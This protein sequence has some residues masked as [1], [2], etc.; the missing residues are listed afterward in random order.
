MSRV[1]GGGGA[2]GVPVAASSSSAVVPC[3]VRNS[4]AGALTF[5]PCGN[6][7]GATGVPPIAIVEATRSASCSVLSVIRNAVAPAQ[8]LHPQLDEVGR[9]V[10]RTPRR[11]GTC[12]CRGAGERVVAGARVGRNARAAAARRCRRRGSPGRGTRHRDRRSPPRR[13]SA[14]PSSRRRSGAAARRPA[15]RRG[16]RDRA[17]AR[18]LGKRACVGERRRCR[19]PEHDRCPCDP[20]H[21]HPGRKLLGAR[22]RGAGWSRA[23][24]A[25]ARTAR[26]ASSRPA[27][28]AP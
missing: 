22:R 27:R 17:A 13:G 16:C 28:A 11:S 10:A 12:R 20:S 15:A 19:T 9:V 18:G 14:A 24:T 25:A 8:R 7:R 4:S 6:W 1:T 21:L 2:T 26:R 5:A 3:T 23:P